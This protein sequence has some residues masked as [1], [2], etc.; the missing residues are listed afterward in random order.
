[1][2][3]HFDRLVANERIVAYA[4]E[5]TSTNQR[6]NFL[7]HSAGNLL[8]KRS[9]QCSVVFV[10]LKNL[11]SDSFLGGTVPFFSLSNLYRVRR[12][13]YLHHLGNVDIP[14]DCQV[15]LVQDLTYTRRLIHAV[16][17]FY[18]VNCNTI[19][20]SRAI[21][22]YAIRKYICLEFYRVTR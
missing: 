14:L 2:T 13:N 11:R 19:Y 21:S 10:P 7:N 1:M 4:N 5:F 18:A 9:D 15:G 12:V 16:I 17:S 20:F 22:I 3:S 6:A 8:W